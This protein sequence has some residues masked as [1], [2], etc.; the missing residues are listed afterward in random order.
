[1]MQTLEFHDQRLQLDQDSLA[2]GAAAPAALGNNPGP[3][4]PGYIAA[5]AQSSRFYAAAAVPSLQQQAR[6]MS[7]EIPT[8]AH[9]SADGEGVVDTSQLAAALSA[10]PPP[11]APAPPPSPKSDNPHRTLLYRTT[12]SQL[13]STLSSSLAGLGPDDVLLLYLQANSLRSVEEAK[14]AERLMSEQQQLQQRGFGPGQGGAEAVPVAVA[15]VVAVTNGD[16]AHG[17]AAVGGDVDGAAVDGAVVDGAVAD[18][19]TAAAA[20]VE[21]CLD[22]GATEVQPPQQQ[23]PQQQ[24]AASSGASVAP[25]RYG[26]GWGQFGGGGEL[27]GGSVTRV[28]SVGGWGQCLGLGPLPCVGL[29]VPEPPPPLREVGCA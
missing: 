25:S 27:G 28:G 29:A 15:T 20:A 12:V 14:S 23:Q 2:D 21:A 17:P 5:A 6:S 19:A 10:P 7:T 11:A 13:L 24:A 8:T 26:W 1:M 18:R 16:V 3:A 22:G 9:L 4:N